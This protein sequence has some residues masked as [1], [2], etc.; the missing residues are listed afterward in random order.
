[1]TILAY[2]GLATV[3]QW[4]YEKTEEDWRGEKRESGHVL[5]VEVGEG[6]EPGGGGANSG[7]FR[8]TREPFKPTATTGKRG[9]S[10]GDPPPLLL[11]ERAIAGRWEESRDGG[12]N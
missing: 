5:L 7:S 3:G 2:L 10:H 12:L 11:L 8:P 6:G 4:E 9:R 1:M